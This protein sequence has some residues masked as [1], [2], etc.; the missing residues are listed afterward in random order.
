[1]I[2]NVRF[3]LEVETNNEDYNFKNKIYLGKY[4][5]LHWIFNV[6]T[7][8]SRIW[9]IFVLFVSQFYFL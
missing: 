4:S 3:G 6:Y 1:M 8:N 9:M 2:Q 7:S 5:E